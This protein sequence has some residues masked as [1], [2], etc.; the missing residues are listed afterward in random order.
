MTRLRENEFKRSVKDQLAKRVAYR[1]TKPDCRKPT[2]GPKA[3]SNDADSIGR[4]AH[5]CAASPEGPRYDAS[6][7]S[8]EISSFDNGLWLCAN[9]ASEIDS[10]N[11]KYSIETLKNWKK[12]VEQLAENEKGNNLPSKNDA[13]QML[14]VAM[15]N[16]KKVIPSMIENV[17]R[18]SSDSLEQ[19][20][21]RF[22]VKSSFINQLPVFE[23]FAKENVS[24]NLKMNPKN[25]QEF[26]QNYFNWT[27]HGDDLDIDSSEIEIEDSALFKEIFN[28]KGRLK[29]GA[30]QKDALIKVWT[31]LPNGKDEHVDDLL[32]KIF[33]GTEGFKFSGHSASRFL[34]I[35]I[36]KTNYEDQAGQITITLNLAMWNDVDI[37]KLPYFDKYKNFFGGLS[38]GAEFFIA[39][40][41][42]G[43]RL[44]L[45]KKMSVK[46][47]DY[48]QF[49]SCYLVYTNAARVI[50]KYTNQSIK[51][52][53]DQAFSAE[54]YAELLDLQRIAEG[55]AIATKENLKSAII[56]EVCFENQEAID[57]LEKSTEPTCIKFSE[58]SNLNLS[59][60]GQELL[61]PPRETILYPV[62]L[63]AKTNSKNF[64][65][66]QNVRV[67]AVPLDNF[68]MTTYFELQK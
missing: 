28:Q 40:E 8:E 34:E 9:H 68:H 35:S 3:N 39:L 64:L 46:E 12:Q 47:I 32:G 18:A 56:L 52:K 10:N 57:A 63:R 6:M 27:K 54:Q 50:A 30:P 55:K 61:L 66:G 60:F 21:P 25:P 38:K 7:T 14:Q 20:D 43:N 51:F 5:I 45:T 15:G 53:S 13:V 29:I 67:E 37:T 62:M 33:V 31:V 16:S 44:F 2:I 58:N 42:E 26:A 59:V 36:K 17:H 19:L 65:V 41:V 48:F 1:C 22:G 49:T 4:A 23:I 11:S 24:I